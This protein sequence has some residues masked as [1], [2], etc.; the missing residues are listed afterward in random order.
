MTSKLTPGNCHDLKVSRITT[1]SGTTE[2]QARRKLV[3]ENYFPDPTGELRAKQSAAVQD[4][5]VYTFALKSKGVA[6]PF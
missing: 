2:P 5:G 6:R 1:T 3:F 4:V